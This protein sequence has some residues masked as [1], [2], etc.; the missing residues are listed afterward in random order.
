MAQHHRASIGFDRRRHEAV[1]TGAMGVV[2][3]AVIDFIGIDTV[4]GAVHLTI[5]DTLAWDAAHL[6]L[7]QT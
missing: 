3:A 5:A 7:L 6:R 4:S 2:Q 1:V